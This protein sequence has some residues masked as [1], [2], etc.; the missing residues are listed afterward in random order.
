MHFGDL[1]M[2]EWIMW[3]K[4]I[5]KKNASEHIFFLTFIVPQFWP[6]MP[7]MVGQNMES[8]ANQLHADLFHDLTVDLVA[9]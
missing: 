1:H 3:R 5:N 6:K 8:E 2:H 9:F 7:M 4:R